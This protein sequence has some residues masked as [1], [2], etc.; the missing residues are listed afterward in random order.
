MPQKIIGLDIGS[1][2]IKAVQLRRTFRGF[3]LI[4]FHEKEI[5]REGEMAP[6]DAVVQ[7][8]TELFGEGRI[9]GDLLITS[10]PGHQVS[11]RIIKLPFADRK[12]MDKV[13]PF[14]I[15]GYT[16]FNIEEMVVS[17]HIVKVEKGGAQILALLV[18]KD[19]LR[20]HLETLERAKI[21][22]KIVDL[23]MDPVGQACEEVEERTGYHVLS[24]RHD[25]FGMC[26]DCIERGQPAT[27]EQ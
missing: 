10:I 15:E 20:D 27:E 3:E 13:I 4:G 23:D 18:K 16:P 7:A 19:V 26:P 25:Y 9:A 6:S 2:S 11:A 5:P 12:K 24:H 1:H 17:Y 22:P 21:S 8:L 14:D